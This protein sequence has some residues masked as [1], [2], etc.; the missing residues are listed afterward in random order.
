MYFPKLISGDA[1]SNSS[2]SNYVDR[3]SRPYGQR[4]QRAVT[5]PISGATYFWC[6]ERTRAYIDKRENI[7][8]C[9]RQIL[10]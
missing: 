9:L 3:E 4:Y 10:N 2:Y 5:K 7:E 8:T 1:E 6:L